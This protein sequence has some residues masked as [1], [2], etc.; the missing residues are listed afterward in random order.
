MSKFQHIIDILP[1]EPPFL[2]VDTLT[3]INE[4]G[5]IG[6]YLIKKDEYFFKG[7]FPGFPV[8]PGVILT[9]I[10]AQIGLVSYGIYLLNPQDLNED[11]LPVFSSA[12]IDFLSAVKPGDE[13]KVES[14]KIYFRFGKLKC[15]VNAWVKDTKV[16]HG[17][18]S[19]I[20]INKRQ[21]EKE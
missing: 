2:F 19:G 20:I 11:I 15:S 8:V 5:S 10:M 21:I 13:V 7:H 14:K 12:N 1:Y 4:Q 17:E 16:A 6:T 3:E 18:F 9:E